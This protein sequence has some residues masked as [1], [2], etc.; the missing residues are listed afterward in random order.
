METYFDNMFLFSMNDGVVHTRFYPMAHYL[1]A[2][3][4]GLKR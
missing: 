4:T 3:C 1:I 2:V